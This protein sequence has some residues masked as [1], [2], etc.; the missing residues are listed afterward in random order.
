LKTADR[1]FRIFEAEALRART[2][3]ERLDD[4]RYGAG[5]MVEPNTFKTLEAYGKNRFWELHHFFA[6]SEAIELLACFSR[7]TVKRLKGRPNYWKITAI[8]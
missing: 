3:I 8:K 2:E 1:Q 5:E 4:P 6:K 7:A